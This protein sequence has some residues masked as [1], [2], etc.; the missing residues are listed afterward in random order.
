MR[1]PIDA[2]IRTRALDPTHSFCITA[3]A[4]SG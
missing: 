1:E 3:P 2:A 4:G